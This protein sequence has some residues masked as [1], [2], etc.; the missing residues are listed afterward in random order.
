MKKLKKILLLSI[1][2]LIIPLFTEA[3]IESDINTNIDIN[4]GGVLGLAEDSQGNVITTSQKTLKITKYDKNKNMIWQ[5]SP[6]LDDKQFEPTAVAVDSNDNIYVIAT[7][8]TLTTSEPGISGFFRKDE[9]NLLKYDASGNLI[10]A[11]KLFFDNYTYVANQNI[12]IYNDEI[13]YLFFSCENPVEK[14]F[15]GTIYTYDCLRNNRVAKITLDGDVVFNTIYSSHTS[16]LISYASSGGSA[17]IRG[18]PGDLL[19]QEDG[20]YIANRS[21]AKIDYQGNLLHTYGNVDLEASSITK[22]RENE[23]IV[24]REVYEEGTEKTK[25]LKLSQNLELI[26][27]EQLLD[28]GATVKKIR[29]VPNGYFMNAKYSTGDKK[30]LH[31]YYTDN[32]FNIINSIQLRNKIY[33]TELME[34]S[35]K[36]A[37]TILIADNYNNNPTYGYYK[38]VVEKNE[39]TKEIKIDNNL[40]INTIF[41]EIN[42]E[43]E[44]DK[45]RLV[46]TIEDPSILKIENGIIVP[47]KK[48]ET[49]ISTTF[50]DKEI[51]V[52][53]IVKDDLVKEILTNPKTYSTITLVIIELFTILLL[54]YNFL[55]K[56]KRKNT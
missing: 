30:G 44:I 14:G 54:G 24:T 41:D 12:K 48:G 39:L 53:V 56:K 4:E 3:K 1:I 50:G 33:S 27:E 9:T 19:F 7:N 42:I 11:K 2:M 16:Q 10:Y 37:D 28:D 32:D 15:S 6:I 55:I 46:W 45:D 47:L 43:E 23:F 52:R 22:S 29:K 5:K 51:I 38:F 36:N 21:V 35:L 8:R 34:I 17:T 40:E 18:I 49:I 25:Y 20:F 13:Y 26:K 31:I